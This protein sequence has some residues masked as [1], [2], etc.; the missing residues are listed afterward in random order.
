MPLRWAAIMQVRGGNTRHCISHACNNNIIQLH[1]KIQNGWYQTDHTPLDEGKH[2]VLG[3]TLALVTNWID[4]FDNYDTSVNY[5]TSNTAKVW[6]NV[7]SNWY[8]LQY[9][10]KVENTLV[11]Q[12]FQQKC[13]NKLESESMV[14]NSESTLSKL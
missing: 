11:Q 1:A 14:A 2:Y 4:K 10:Q 6:D 13:A 5:I 9:V 8:S 12:K 3:L 7:P